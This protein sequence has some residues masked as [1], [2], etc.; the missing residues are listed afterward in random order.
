MNHIDIYDN[1]KPLVFRCFQNLF[2]QKYDEYKSI[3]PIGAFIKS[4]CYLN[5]NLPRQV[6]KTTFI[7]RFIRN[8][9]HINPNYRFL[10]VAPKMLHRENLGCTFQNEGCELPKENFILISNLQ[11]TLEENPEYDFVFFDEC[12]PSLEMIPPKCTKTLFVSL[13]T[14]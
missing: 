7:A 6:G 4:F 8:I 10:V 11:R 2:T 5:F 13:T 14:K 12:E 1:L 9:L 3:M